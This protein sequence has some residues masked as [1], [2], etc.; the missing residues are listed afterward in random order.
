MYTGAMSNV[1]DLKHPVPPS[2]A[3]EGAVPGLEPLSA[4][5]LAGSDLVAWGDPEPLEWEARSALTAQGR[6]RHYLVF[7]GFAMIGGVISWWQSSPF[8]FVTVLLGL[9][10]WELHERLGRPVKVRIDSTGVSLDE[11]HFPHAEL[12]SFDIH[13]MTDTAAVLSLATR[14]W[15]SAHLRIPLGTQDPY[16]VRAALL[17]FV[18]EERHGVGPIDRY[19][20][21][22]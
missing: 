3:A 15:H 10:A 5:P 13:R 1:L 2:P 16:K 9:V 20:S 18:P 8:M 4:T 21:E 6:Y 17:H 7:S 22:V 14:R 19:L 12:S 11:R